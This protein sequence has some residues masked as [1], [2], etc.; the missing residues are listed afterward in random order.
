M[1]SWIER[2]LNVH[3][4]DLGR[5]TLLCSSLFL[6]ITAYKIGGV[7][8]AA[9]FLSRFQARQLAYADISSCPVPL[10]DHQ[11]QDVALDVGNNQ[12]I[13]NR[14][15]LEN[16]FRHD[17][18]RDNF[19]HPDLP[20]FLC[21][22]F[23]I[24]RGAIAQVHRAARLFRAGTL[25]AKVI[26]VLRHQRPFLVNALNL[27][28][29]EIIEDDEVRPVTRRDRTVV[30]QPVM[31]RG[32]NRPHLNCGDG[33]H[34]VFDGLADRMIDTLIVCG[35][36]TPALEAVRSQALFQVQFTF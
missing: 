17:L 2:A 4:G 24:L 26:P 13:G 36:T 1:K 8:A 32:V 11:L 10:D 16:F 9:L 3:P 5:G 23:E 33:R 15:R 22:R 27:K 31:A 12:A 6:I 7:A 18:M 21:V 20:R 28:L 30:L 35:V 29:R 25:F 14:G 19:D 34:A